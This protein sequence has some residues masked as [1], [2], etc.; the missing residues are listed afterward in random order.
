MPS[1]TWSAKYR[2][3]FA[4]FVEDLNAMIKS[5]GNDDVFVHAKTETVRRV[6]LA[7][8]TAWLTNLASIIIII[9]IIQRQLIRRRNMA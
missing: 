2:T 8:C 7:Q 3:K 6:E 4:M 9:I 1:N 5:V